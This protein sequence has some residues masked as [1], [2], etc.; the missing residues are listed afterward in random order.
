MRGQHRMH[1]RVENLSERP[2]LAVKL[3]ATNKGVH[4]VSHHGAFID[5][6]KGSAHQDL[7]V[8][9]HLLEARLILFRR[10]LLRSPTFVGTVKA[11]DK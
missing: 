1:L 10:A 4:L 5:R 11:E 6:F 2:S 7:K 8:F 3:F 9:Y